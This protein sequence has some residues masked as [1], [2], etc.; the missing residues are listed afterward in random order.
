MT[1]ENHGASIC[2]PHPQAADIVRRL[3]SEGVLTWNGRGRVRVS[4]HGYNGEADVARA[5][6]A[7]RAAFSAP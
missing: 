6:A 4:F 1:P 5:F 2:L 3:E 7:L